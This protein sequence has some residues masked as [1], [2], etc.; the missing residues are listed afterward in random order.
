MR[1]RCI[2]EK[3][4]LLYNMQVASKDGNLGSTC[5]IEKMERRADHS[6]DRRLS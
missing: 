4:Y 1:E 3:Y 2:D 5:E 6:A